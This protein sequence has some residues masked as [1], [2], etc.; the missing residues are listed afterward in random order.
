MAWLRTFAILALPLALAG[1]GGGGGGSAPAPTP[2]GPLP[3]SF[4]VQSCLD[5]VVYPGRTLANV[6]VPDTIKVDVTK[7]AGFP[8]GRRLTDSV[9]PINLAWFTAM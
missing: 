7:P 6:V 8:N 2:V 9:M 3:T 5:Q 4:N 1:C